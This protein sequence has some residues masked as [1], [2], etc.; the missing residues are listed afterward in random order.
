MLNLPVRV[1][2]INGQLLSKSA[3]ACNQNDSLIITVSALLRPMWPVDSTWRQPVSPSDYDEWLAG[4][5]KKE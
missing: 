1:V 4:T 5:T 3:L 2:A